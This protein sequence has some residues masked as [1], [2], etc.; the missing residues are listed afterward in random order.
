MDMGN[1]HFGA[2][3][4]G[5]TPDRPV[6]VAAANLRLDS[7]AVELSTELA[8]NGISAIILKGPSVARWL[9]RDSSRRYIDIDLLINPGELDKT[10]RILAG[11]GFRSVPFPTLDRDV[12]VRREW[13]RDGIAIDLHVTLDLLEHLDSRAVWEELSARTEPMELATGTVTVLAPGPRALYVALHALAHG[14][15][16]QPFRDLTRAL[17]VLPRDVWVDAAEVARS[18]GAEALIADALAMRPEGRALVEDLGLPQGSKRTR[19]RRTGATATE[20]SAAVTLLHVRRMGVM[21]ALRFLAAKAFPP[22]GYL[23]TRSRLA[24]R[25]PIGLGIAYL[26]RPLLLIVAAIKGAIALLRARRS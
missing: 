20:E 9:Y 12:P 13:D 7:I 5:A 15:R 24:G 6:R 16:P 19:L 21:E 22:P 3:P 17:E 25:G 8:G 14:D 1:H 10:S 26:I 11:L 2:S 4:Q 23:R 18:L